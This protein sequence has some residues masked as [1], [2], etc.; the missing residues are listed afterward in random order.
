MGLGWG[1]FGV[2][3]YYLMFLFFFFS[4]RRRHTRCSRDWSSDVCS[5]D[6]SYFFAPPRIWEN[7][8]TNVMIRIEDAA[9]LK[10]RL[11]KFF[12]E[13]AQDLERARLSDRPRSAWR[14]LLY[15]LG[16]LLVYGPLRD[17]LGMRRIRIA[18]TAGEAIGSEIIV[19][20]RALGINVKQLYGM[21]EASVFVA[22][23]KDGDVRLDTVGTPMPQVEIKIS[24]QGEVMFRT[25]GVFQGYF[26]N[27]EA[28]AAT[29]SDG[30]IRSGDAGF[31]D[32]SGHLKIIDRAN[33]VCRLAHGN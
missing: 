13:V 26:K 28:T 12:L 30:W 5:S 20:F 18:Y 4:S 7:M 8:L 17:N 9:W 27:P 29:L 25:P 1:V 24:E 6:L 23:Q 31:L 16:R 33:D 32:A 14:R 11:V 22:V 10:R 15:P 2:R 3:V 21:T 19:F